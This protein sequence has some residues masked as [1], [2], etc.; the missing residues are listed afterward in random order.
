VGLS[1]NDPSLLKGVLNVDDTKLKGSAGSYKSAV[2]NWDKFFVHF[3]TRDC[4]V[5]A[6]LTDGA[7]TTITKQMIPLAGDGK[8]PGDA[9]LHGKFSAGLRAYVVPNYERG[10]DPTKQL[11]PIL[12]TFTRDS[13]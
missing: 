12:I 8:A 3:F 11:T 5:I 9:H 10:P 13:P 6:G 2:T 1:V 7:C 4:A